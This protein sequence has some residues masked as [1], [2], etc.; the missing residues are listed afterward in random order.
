MVKEMIETKNLNIY[1]ASKAQMEKF[2][3]MQTDFVL[4]TAY[5]EMLNGAL[6]HPEQWKWYAI[7][8]VELK[9]GT[10]IGELSFKGLSASG[11]AE[12]G[13][14][15]EEKYQGNGYATE[16]IKALTTWALNQPNVTQVEAETEPD[17]K[18]SQRVL[19]KCGFMPTGEM[20]TEGPRFVLVK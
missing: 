7:W 8:M 10:H 13:Y 2:I 9:S 16:A 18:A 4:Q 20:G 14:G 3:A 12:I 5:T 11:V 1:P 19:I 17:N 6:Q 15:I